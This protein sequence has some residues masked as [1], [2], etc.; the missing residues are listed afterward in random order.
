MKILSILADENIP[1]LQHYFDKGLRTLVDSGQF[2][3]ISIRTMPGRAIQAEHLQEAQLLLV[4]SVT[5]VTAELI[6]DSNVRFVGSCTIGTDHLDLSGLDRLGVHWANAP[7]CNATA[8]AEYV[9]QQVMQFAAQT[10]REIGS[11]RVGIVGYGN[12]G[13]RV[14]DKLK[15]LGLEQ[16][17]VNDPPLQACLLSQTPGAE[18]V[19]VAQSVP[20]VPLE[21]IVKND[22]VTLH[23]PWVRG[24]VYPTHHL[25]TPEL[26]AQMQRTSLLI[27]TA[28]GALMDLQ[29]CLSWR[30]E[31][32]EAD[33]MGSK[34]V[35]DVYE[36]EPGIDPVCF[37]NLSCATPHIAGHS[38]I[39]K[40]QGTRQ[41]WQAALAYF[42]QPEPQAY[43]RQTSSVPLDLLLRN[44]SLTAADWALLFEQVSE[45]MATDRN[46]RAAFAQADRQSNAKVFEAVRRGYRP[47]RE[48]SQVRVVAPQLNDVDME[49]L[50]QL[51]AVVEQ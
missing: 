42:G 34:W 4:R 12:V 13:H 32:S 33:Q 21:E 51:G 1:G 28:R 22:I 43:P 25:I 17:Q 7:G 15:L 18:F 36:N 50:R 48:M 41:V 6:S 37:D 8:V 44:D 9:V 45:L 31:L 49:R 35:F 38:Q 3:D 29:A 27:N 5:K 23:V 40:E 30:A 20:F 39:G 46:F 24:G 47:R 2:S 19:S 16:I 10:E 14:A 26:L 11:L